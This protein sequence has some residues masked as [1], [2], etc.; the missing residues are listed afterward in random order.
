MTLQMIDWRFG[1]GSWR[2]SAE[3]ERLARAA[4]RS[5]KRSMERRKKK[6]QQRNSAERKQ[7][8]LKH[9]RLLNKTKKAYNASMAMES[10]LASEIQAAMRMVQ[11]KQ[12]QLQKAQMMSAQL[13][14]TYQQQ[15]LVLSAARRQ[16]YPQVLR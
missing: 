7:P 9:V 5:V 3:E 14:Q 8:S 15:Y 6:R 12:A 1:G 2:G 4:S 13:A 10:T 16:H 11:L